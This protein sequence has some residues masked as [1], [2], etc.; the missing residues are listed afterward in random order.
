MGAGA[1]GP[2]GT[3]L[4]PFQ[5]CAQASSSDSLCLCASW[6][7][8]APRALP[9]TPPATLGRAWRTSCCPLRVR[10]GAGLVALE[11]QWLI[12][13]LGNGQRLP[14]S[15]PATW[16][17]RVARHVSPPSLPLPYSRQGT[18]RILLQ[19]GAP[20]GAI[21]R[22]RYRWRLLHGGAE[23]EP[24]GG[25][26]KQGLATRLPRSPPKLDGAV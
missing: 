11:Q 2:G 9:P 6:A 21:R 5:R 16:Y 3:T 26:M 12:A 8:A 15:F 23:D 19:L 20:R 22:R 25:A 14:C 10:F 24:L 1:D 17:V 4:F 13:A 18:L 7:W